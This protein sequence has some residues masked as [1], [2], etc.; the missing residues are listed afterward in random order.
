MADLLRDY[1]DRWTFEPVTIGS[2]AVATGFT[3]RVAGSDVWRVLSVS[4]VLVA[5]GNAASRIARVEYLNAAGDVFAAVASPFTVTAGVT[6]RLTFAVGLQQFGANAA[7]HIGGPL[8]DLILMDGLAVRVAVTA[9]QAG[10]QLSGISLFVAQ[11]TVRPDE[12][13][14]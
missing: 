5:D 14:G 4:F 6:S 12:N 7:A 8:P 13:G 2:P 1:G 11:S 10:D 3:K 9:I